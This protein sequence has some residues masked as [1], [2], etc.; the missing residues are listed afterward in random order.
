MAMAIS[1]QMREALAQ[2]ALLTGVL[3]PNAHTN[4]S[5]ILTSGMHSSR[6]V[7]IQFHT[8]VGL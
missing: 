3:L 7:S 1:A 4:R 6:Y 2:F 5:T 8:V